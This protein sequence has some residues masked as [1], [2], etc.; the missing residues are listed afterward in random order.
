MNGGYLTYQNLAYEH[1]QELFEH[2]CQIYDQ[3]EPYGGL[4]HT[5][6]NESVRKHE[7]GD[8]VPSDDYGAP[9]L[10]FMCQVKYVCVD[11]FCKVAFC[12]ECMKDYINYSAGVSQT[13]EECYRIWYN[14]NKHRKLSLLK[15]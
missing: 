6:T 15:P 10:H 11:P 12:H 14:K 3:C 5:K 7:L 13:N 4:I 8:W 9:N 2:V 1:N